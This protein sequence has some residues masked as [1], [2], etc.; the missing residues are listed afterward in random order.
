MMIFEFWYLALFAI[1]SRQRRQNSG[2]ITNDSR[3]L[4]ERLMVKSLRTTQNERI[5]FQ[6]NRKDC[7]RKSS[8]YVLLDLILPG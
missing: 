8:Q 6:S 5:T 4:G 7:E 3:R 1:D 2:G